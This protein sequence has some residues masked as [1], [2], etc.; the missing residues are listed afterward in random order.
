M[1]RVSREHFSVVHQL[2]A[3]VLCG[4]KIVEK[5]HHR[6]TVKLGFSRH[7]KILIFEK[8]LNIVSKRE[9]NSFV[10]GFSII[11]IASA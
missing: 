3:C 10:R 2:Y 9:V 11:I 1:C 8:N 7:F 5:I 6:K 4:K